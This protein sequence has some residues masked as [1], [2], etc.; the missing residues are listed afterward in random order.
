MRDTS[1]Q[2]CQIQMNNSITLVPCAPLF[3]SL[4]LFSLFPS[5]VFD[6]NKKCVTGTVCY[7]DENQIY[8]HAQVNLRR[9]T[10]LEKKKNGDTMLVYPSFSHPYSI[11]TETR[12]REEEEEKAAIR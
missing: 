9:F 5:D 4:G 7:F 3:L 12:A 8:T 2:S 10:S 6:S 11:E 1:F